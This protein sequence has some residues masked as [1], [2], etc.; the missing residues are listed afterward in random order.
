M[1]R[2]TVY[3]GR[4]VLESENARAEVFPFGALLNEYA[5]RAVDGA[6]H[7][8]VCGY[9]SPYAAEQ[10]ITE[11]FYSAKLSPFPCRLKHGRYAF[12]ATAYRIDKHVLNGH[13]IHGLLY[14][15]PFAVSGSG[16]DASAAWVRLV[17][18][19]RHEYAGYPFDYRIEVGYTLS[20]NGL[21]V[22]TEVR[23]LSA[24]ELPVADGWHPYF[25]LNGTADDWT[26]RI[27]STTQLAFDADLLPTGETLADNRFVDGASLKN[28]ALDNSFIL[29]DFVQAA[30]TLSDGVWRLDIFPDEHYPY[31]QVYIPPERTAVAIENLSGAPDCFNNGLGLIHLPSGA[32]R[33]FQTR[34]LLQEAA[35]G[36]AN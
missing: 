11:G 4:V 19:Y 21:T 5:V 12:N 3:P 32:S 10:H 26:L 8:A 14:D 36:C 33:R 16:A 20:E 22:A 6:R 35:D 7:N 29:R 13:A 9:A 17:Y 30:C 24:S 18:D 2:C 15:A 23:N 31:L 25:A 27:N 28:I 34:Y 1:Y